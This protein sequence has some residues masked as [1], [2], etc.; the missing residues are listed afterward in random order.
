M[1]DLGLRLPDKSYGYSLDDTVGLAQTAEDRGYHSVWYPEANRRDVF[2][3][4]GQIARETESIRLAPG[5]T[6]V[7]ARVPVQLAMAAATLDEVSDGRAMVGLG[8]SSDITVENWYGIDYDRP[9]RHLRETI[10]IVN[11]AVSENRVDYDGDIFQV[12]NYPSGVESVQDSIP[13]YNAALGETNRKLTGEFADGWLPVNVPFEKLPAFIE[14]IQEAAADAGRDPD[15]ITI[16]PYIISCVSEDRERA[17]NQV[18]GL[19]A[20]YIGAMD[21]YAGVFRRFGFEDQ[22]DHIR[23][24]WQDGDRDI[25][26]ERISDSLLDSVAIGG[27]PEE[28]RERLQE[29]REQGVDIPVVYP[30]QAPQ[31]LIE[32][33]VTELGSF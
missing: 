19:L 29:Y 9:L 32:T 20:Y 30:P 22:V 3:V 25:A 4:L 26:R 15:E 31:D 16:A 24:A 12:N 13:L 10:E 18:R 14:D 33:T 8:A 11:L 1:S 23:D 2:M 7:Y 27:T 28:G 21:Y 6:P 17:R 5:I